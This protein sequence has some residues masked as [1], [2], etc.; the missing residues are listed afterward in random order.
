MDAVDPLHVQVQPFLGF[1]LLGVEAALDF[2]YKL[3][4]KVDWFGVGVYFWFFVHLEIEDVEFADFLFLFGL[5][6]LVSDGFEE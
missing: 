1:A 2:G 4:V 6:D 5:V 3:W